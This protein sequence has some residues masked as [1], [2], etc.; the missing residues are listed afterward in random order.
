MI[1]DLICLTARLI[2][3]LSVRWI[4]CAP[5][6]KQRIYFANHTSHLDFVVI[7]TALPKSLRTKTRAVAAKDYWQKGKLRPYLAKEI[8]QTVLIE[9][10]HIALHDEEGNPLQ[11]ML[12]A[13]QQ[14]SSLIVF[15]EGTRGIQQEIQPFKPGIYHLHQARPDAELIPVY[16][17]NL[18]RVLP[19]GEFLPVPIL[20]SVTFGPP[21]NVEKGVL[22]NDFLLRAR[23]AVED[24]KSL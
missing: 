9:R 13:L 15:P 11:A 22:K 4:G 7:W 6:D 3:G 20:G 14:G 16:L 1:A 19:K 8:F 17:E 10:K 12:Q 5:E 2:S 23:Q 24:L 18:S 21:F